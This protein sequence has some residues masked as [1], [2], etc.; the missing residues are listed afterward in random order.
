MTFEVTSK[1]SSWYA[2]PF[3][4][5]ITFVVFA[6]IKIV[7]ALFLKETLNSAANDSDTCHRGK[8]LGRGIL[9]KWQHA[10]LLPPKLTPSEKND[11]EDH[12]I[13]SKTLQEP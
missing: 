10:P 2:V 8:G 9:F 13:I 7:T 12:R 11:L 5:Y 4:L 1:V 6:V 3:L